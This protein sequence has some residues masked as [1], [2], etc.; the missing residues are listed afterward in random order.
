MAGPLAKGLP[1][2]V[3]GQERDNPDKDFVFLTVN[4]PEDVKSRKNQRSIRSRVMRDIGRSRRTRKKCP[5]QVIFSLQETTLA[6]DR[7]TLTIHD[8]CIPNSLASWPFPVEL[9]WRSRELVHFMNSESD[10]VYRPFRTVWF[11]MALTDAGAFKLAMANAS[12]F[13]AQSKD[14][15][16]FRYENCS[17]T[18]EYYGQCLRLVIKQLEDPDDC[19]GEGVINAILGLICHDLYVGT[20]DRWTAHIT[21]LRLIYKR[22][23]GFQCL[24]PNL[25]LF[26]SWF[27]V[28]GCAIYDKRPYFSTDISHPE[29]VLTEIKP[30]LLQNMKELVQTSAELIPVANALER[31]ASLAQFINVNSADPNFWSKEDDMDP[32]RLMGPILH[33]LLSMPRLETDIQNIDSISYLREMTRL[34]M[35]I[36]MA[37]VK[38]AYSFSFNELGLLDKKFSYLLSTYSTLFETFFQDIQL[39]S[40]LTIVAL[41]PQSKNRNLYITQARR[42]M[43]LLGIISANTALEKAR[44][45]IWIDAIAGATLDQSLSHEIDARIVTDILSLR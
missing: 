41:L 23:G 30:L 10:Y 12:M 31:I 44:G 22:R 37:I 40:I 5:V 27:D 16:K 26:A 13:L 11:S 1:V 45:M 35:L 43:S 34:A 18:L 6:Y 42:Q 3:L 8:E 28:L 21:G 38:R 39:W 20:W 15:E 2:P 4:H 25:S 14:P 33:I 7:L 36:I 17:E 24:H 32:L 29:P 19:L 9:D